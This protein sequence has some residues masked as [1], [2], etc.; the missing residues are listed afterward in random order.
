MERLSGGWGGGRNPSE[1]HKPVEGSLVAA[2]PA[3]LRVALRGGHVP[4]WEPRGATP[5]PAS[6]T[7]R[8]GREVLRWPRTGASTG[9][10]R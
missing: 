6:S 1:A 2:A 5:P 4:P 7:C 10:A 3:G 8:D 9:P